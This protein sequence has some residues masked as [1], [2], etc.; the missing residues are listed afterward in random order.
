MKNWFKGI[1]TLEELKVAYKKLAMKNHPDLGG[2][3]QA[4]QEIN[5]EYDMLSKVL[6][7]ATTGTTE[8]HQQEESNAAAYK[9]VIM[10]IIH[11]EGLEIELC[12]S[13]LWVSGNT[14]EWKTELKASG[15][16]WA[17]KKAM[18]YWRAAEY[19]SKGRK[20]TS[21]ADIRTKYGSERISGSFR[22][23]LA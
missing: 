7:H 9:D 1:N 21:M 6:V 8:E 2:S 19:K 23:T 4:M 22:P 20:N 11:L 18:W 14:K 13:W 17:S 3:V 12:G 16:R 15:F 10:N 5:A